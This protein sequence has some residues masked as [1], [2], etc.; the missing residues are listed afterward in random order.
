MKYKIRGNDLPIVDV[1][2]N[3]GESVYT[4]SGGMGWMSAN[5]SMKTNTKGGLKKAFGRMLSGES[6]FMVTYTCDSGSGFISFCNEFPGNVMPVNLQSGQSLICQKDAFMFAESSVNLKTKF[7][8]KLGAGF[9]GGEGFFLQ[10]LTGPG[11]AFLEFS[12]E[13]TEYNLQQGQTLKVDPG[14]LAAFEPTVNYN[15]SRIKGIKNILFGGEGLFLAILS[16][17]GKVWLQSMPSSNLAKKIAK[18][19][20]KR[21]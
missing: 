4:E 10:E 18:N 7:T 14:Y 1:Q 6:L 2:L 12:G 21:R 17:P 20:P 9:F 16:G 13:I 15:I 19:I 8:K 3:A 5:I 11:Q